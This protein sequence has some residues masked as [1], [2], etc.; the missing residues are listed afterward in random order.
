MTFQEHFHLPHY[1]SSKIRAEITHLYAS[2]G[3]GNL[4]QAIIT[5]FE[6]IFL[7]HVVGLTI[8]EILLF[9][10]AVY[11]IYALIIPLGGKFAAKF[12]YAH[13]IFF[14]IPFQIIFWFLILGSEN[15]V[16]L[17]IPAALAFAISKDFVL[18]S[19]ACKY[20]SFFN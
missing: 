7:Y 11:A 2:V 5:L 13:S 14:S 16:Y 17:L 3:I 9:M 10:G 15:G 6:P 20:V 8:P 12:G 1:F 4:A 19:V 18:A